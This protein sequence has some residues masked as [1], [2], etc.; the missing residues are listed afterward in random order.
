MRALMVCKA[1]LQDGWR[2]PEEERQVIRQDQLLHSFA[3]RQLGKNTRLLEPR[4]AV[5]FLSFQRWVLRKNGGVA[6]ARELGVLHVRANWTQH[7]VSS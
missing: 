6:C 5:R 7:F 2:V 4:Y 1:R 3:Q